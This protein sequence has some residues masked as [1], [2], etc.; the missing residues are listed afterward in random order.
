VLTSVYDRR[1][2]YGNDVALIILLVDVESSTA[3]LREAGHLW[4]KCNKSSR[5]FRRP[6]LFGVRESKLF[7][8]L[9]T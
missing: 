3:E 8:V 4:V 5:T 9:L 7:Y 6:P 2:K 1:S